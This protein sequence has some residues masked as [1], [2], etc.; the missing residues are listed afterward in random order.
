MVVLEKIADLSTVPG[1]V[2][3]AIGVF[4]GVHLGH[5]AVIGKAIADAAEEGGSP[6]VVTFDPHPSKVLRPERAVRLLT[7][8]PHKIRLLKALGIGHLLVIPFTKDF[9]TIPPEEFILAL[10]GACKPLREICVGAKWCFGQ[11]RSGNLALLQKMGDALGFREMGIENVCADGEVI[12]ST[13]IRAAVEKGDLKRASRYLGREFTILGTV[14]KGEQLGRSLGFPT[15]NL[16]AHN[17]QFP[18]DGVYA[19]QAMVGGRMRPGV[20]NIGVRP[21]VQERAGQ[22]LLELHLFDFNEDIYGKEV[23][24]FFRQ[25][26]RHER[27]FAGL[28]ELKSQIAADAEEAKNI[29]CP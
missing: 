3:L 14:I 10:H 7:S 23:E 21:T 26:L 9:A 12:S 17:E 13:L 22:R 29:V 16:S 18:P 24:V 5:Q 2:F 8:T 25:Y 4:D 27:K 15:A 28:A 6:V 19:V 11:N 1:P 20:V